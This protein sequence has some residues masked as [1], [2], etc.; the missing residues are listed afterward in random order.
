MNTMSRRNIQKSESGGGLGRLFLWAA[1]LGVVFSAGI[2]TGQRILLEESLP[3]LI[4]IGNSNE[5]PATPAADNEVDEDARPSIFSFYDALT[6]PEV[7]ELAEAS[8]PNIV[9]PAARQAPAP[10]PDPQPAPTPE[11]EQTAQ[12]EPAPEEP[13]PEE[14]E[15][16]KREPAPVPDDLPTEQELIALEEAS[17]DEEPI[18]DDDEL[19]ARYTLQVASHPSME[20][21]RAEMDRLRGL[22][23]DPHVV[24][25]DVPGQGKFYRVRIGKFHTMDQARSSQDVVQQSQSVQTFVTPL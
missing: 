21:A 8:E 22:G 5:A 20:Q 25:A 16:V 10:E 14:P 12:G 19:P 3:P 9:P 1:V 17:D 6:S 13:A 7:K 11:P 24:A 2:I 18:T 23:L 15:F 4:A